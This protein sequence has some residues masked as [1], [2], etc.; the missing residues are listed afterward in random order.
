VIQLEKFGNPDVEP[1]YRD[2]RPG[3]TRHTLADLSYIKD[4]LGYVAEY[5]LYT[6]LDK[7]IEWY[8]NKSA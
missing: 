1:I 4:K 6:A 5:D 2:F 8:K 7:A 3:D